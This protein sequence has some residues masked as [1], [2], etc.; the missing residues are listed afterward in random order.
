MRHEV[1][2][3]PAYSMLKVTLGEGEEVHAEPGAMVLMREVE[4][5]TSMQG[6]VMKSLMR[7]LLGGESL[8]INTYRAKTDGASVWLAPSSPGDILYLPL[9]SGKLLLQDRAYLAHHGEVEIGVAFRGFK[10]FLSEGQFVWLKAE[11][12]GGLWIAAFGALEVLELAPG[13]RV[14][15]DNF[16]AVAMDSTVEYKIRPFGGLKSAIL[17]G[18]GLVMDLLGPGRVVIQTRTEASFIQSLLPFFP[19]GE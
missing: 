15:V 6:G 12:S 7:S 9:K 14:I 13:E 19:K 5:K 18:E 2:H 1:I 11:G 17:G 8:W 3:G 10:G 4:V 16:H